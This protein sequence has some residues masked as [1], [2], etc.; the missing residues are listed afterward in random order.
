MTIGATYS[1]VVLGAA[2]NIAFPSSSAS[3]W[4]ILN[5]LQLL[6]LLVLVREYVEGTLR[7]YLIKQNIIMLNFN[8]FDLHESENKNIDNFFG[9]LGEKQENKNL[10]DL[11]FKS[12]SAL[13]N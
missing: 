12:T 2:I 9:F 13:M 3:F 5:K 11:G 10:F 7:E 6:V 8:L 1:I 4:V